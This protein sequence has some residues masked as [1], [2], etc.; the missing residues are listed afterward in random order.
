VSAREDLVTAA[1]LGLRRAGAD[2]VDP[3]GLPAPVAEA[4]ASTP[5]ATGAARLLDVVA[6]DVVA[7]RAGS[8]PARHED[9]P[10][11]GPAPAPT[12]TGVPVGGRARARLAAL[13]DQDGETAD[14]L[15][16]TWL[17]AAA[18]RGAVV[19]PPLLPEALA[20]AV[21]PRGGL[22]RDA[23]GPALGT[24]GRWLAAQDAQWAAVLEG[25]PGAAE[26]AQPAR[27][28]MDDPAWSRRTSTER[29]GVVRS[30]GTAV[31]DD[32][33]ERLGR[34]LADRAASVREAAAGALVGIPGSRFVRE[35]TER[36]LACV[37]V[38]RRLLRRTLVVQLPPD[39]PA[40]PFAEVRSGPGGRRGR[41]LRALVAATPPRAW[42]DALGLDPATIVRLGVADD[43]GAL[44]HD[45][46]ATAA[47]RS[48]DV[49]WARALLDT[50]QRSVQLLGVLPADDAA[51]VFVGWYPPG[52]RVDRAAAVGA[53]HEV[54]HVPAPWPSHV[55]DAVVRLLTVTPA[56]DGWQ[57]RPVEHRLVAGMPHDP[58]TERR[59]RAAAD[60]RTDDA[61][62][63]T[64]RT[65][66]D[67]L[68][69][70]RTLL[71]ELA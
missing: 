12:E 45:A 6:L 71:E 57:L 20:R 69:T 32:D 21:R 60:R 16:A 68:V 47:L 56:L 61:P 31:R 52:G 27:E 22:V 48:R 11:R 7:R 49:T 65:V 28:S 43:L 17:R 25:A 54:E 26:R 15:V 34:A 51:S 55:V 10:R 36:A 46:W 23:L 70:R 2:P 3:S 13:L 59:L 38:E 42:E 29:A 62:A 67:A 9:D 19:P 5:R 44:L 1:L 39:D 24:R 64:L 14:V 66:A 58:D 8:P 33:E 18:G 35:C 4:V 53:L 63:R 37:A 30:V 40:S 41:L 50:G